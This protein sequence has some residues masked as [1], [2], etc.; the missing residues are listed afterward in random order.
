MATSIPSFFIEQSMPLERNEIVGMNLNGNWS[1]D[2]KTIKKGIGAHFKNHF[3]KSQGKR[4]IMGDH[5]F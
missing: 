3:S 2:V 5:M 4:P 1:E